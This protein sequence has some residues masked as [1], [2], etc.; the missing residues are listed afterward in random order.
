[1]SPTTTIAFRIHALPDEVLDAVRASGA[2]AAGVP[3]ER[4]VADGGEPLR[5]CLRNATPGE[6]LILFGYQPPLPASP[7]RETGAVYAHAEPCA[8]LADA[9]AYPPEWYGRPQVLRAYDRRG[10]IHAATKVHDGQD[11]EA[12]I[13]DLLIDPDVVQ[14]HS[15]NVAWGC[16]MFAITRA[17]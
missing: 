1:M 14:I 16:Y 12:V 3:A 8:G 6:E 2:D 15:R 5:C 9:H 11:P 7:Y 17:G 13:A 10:W 4:I